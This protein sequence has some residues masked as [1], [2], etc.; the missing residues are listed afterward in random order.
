MDNFEYSIQIND[1]DWEEFY[2]TAE[3]CGL[4]QVS[5]A[6]E[7]ELCLSDTER[8]DTTNCT[9][10]NKP[11]F[12][13]ISLCPPSQEEYP[14]LQISQTVIPQTVHTRNRWFGPD[15]DVLSGSEDEEELGSVTR[16]LCQKEYMLQNKD[17]EQTIDIPLPKPVYHDITKPSN[18]NS[19]SN[20]VGKSSAEYRKPLNLDGNVQYKV[21]P[22]QDKSMMESSS[23]TQVE[24]RHPDVG[25]MVFVQPDGY[26]RLIANLNYSKN[27]PY[28]V[29]DVG[30]SS[31]VN[32]HV[33]DENIPNTSRSEEETMRHSRHEAVL[34]ESLRKD[35]NFNAEDGMF[36]GPASL[37]EPSTSM[38]NGLVYYTMENDVLGNSCEVVTEACVY[39]SAMEQN[40]PRSA[41]EELQSCISQSDSLNIEGKATPSLHSLVDHTTS[42]QSLVPVNAITR[43]WR[44]QVPLSQPSSACYRKTVLTLAEMYDFFL[45]D[46]TD[47]V[48]LDTKSNMA[49]KEGTVCTPEMYE[50]FFLEDAEENRAKSRGSDTSQA[51]STDLVLASSSSVV[52]TWPEACEFFFAD[53]PQDS[54]REGIFFSIPSS[55]IQSVA[56]VIQ[57]FV[58]KG[59]KGLSVRRARYRR[60][61]HGRLIPQE[62]QKTSKAANMSKSGA[63]A[64]YLSPGRSDVCLVFLAFASWAVKSSDLQSSDGWKTALLANIGAVSAIQ[65]LRRRSRG[66]W[67]NSPPQ[68]GDET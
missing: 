50:Y 21:D 34:T 7:E 45:D 13:R 10:S 57:S 54:N 5:L 64:P 41:V 52:A 24:L 33:Q 23:N 30:I 49:S 16:F 36:D 22:F 46:V 14:A 42:T 43:A 67:Q 9:L 2:S 6:T 35:N 26:S 18:E 65:Y 39:S 48:F 32:S 44:N 62:R 66:T 4:T 20:S 51:S 1:R 40:V 37:E 3:E 47:I 27:S 29:H 56:N 38:H 53:G 11:K 63:I 15:Q 28:C 25:R 59:L 31:S 60:G 55:Q 12:I 17:S 58:P 8:E 61:P 19:R 68:P